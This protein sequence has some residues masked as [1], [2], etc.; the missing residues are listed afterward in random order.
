MER[1]KFLKPNN[2]YFLTS[3]LTP[4]S[5]ADLTEVCGNRNVLIEKILRNEIF[6][7][8]GIRG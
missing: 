4:I 2:C 3:Q 1:V 7:G 5:D 8:D 6:Q